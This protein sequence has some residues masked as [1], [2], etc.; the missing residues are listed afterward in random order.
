MELFKDHQIYC[1]IVSTSDAVRMKK[2]FIAVIL[3]V[4]SQPRP[5]SFVC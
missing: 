5:F 3:A 4:V 2:L 1:P